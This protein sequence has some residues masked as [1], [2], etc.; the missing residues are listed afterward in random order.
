MEEDNW[1]HPMAQS[2]INA[3]ESMNAMGDRVGSLLLGNS[4]P[5]RRPQQPQPI[6]QR[7]QERQVEEVDYKQKYFSLLNKLKKQRR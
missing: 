2:I 3:G 4:Q 6:F 7:R 1:E 5:V